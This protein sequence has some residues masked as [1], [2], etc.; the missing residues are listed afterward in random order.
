MNDLDLLAALTGARHAT[1]TT[2]SRA[3]QTCASGTPQ[4]ARHRPSPHHHRRQP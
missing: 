1:A 4:D 3:T 2:G